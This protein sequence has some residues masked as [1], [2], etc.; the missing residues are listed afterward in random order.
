VGALLDDLSILNDAD[1]FRM[2]D[3]AEPVGNDNGRSF[4][5]KSLHGVLD[6][7]LGEGGNAGRG[8][9]QDQYTRVGY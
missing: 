9:I 7:G 4:C 8:F 5:Q 2:A 3:G 1:Q 6:I